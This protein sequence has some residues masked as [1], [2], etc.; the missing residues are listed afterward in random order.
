MN[1]QNQNNPLENKDVNT[2]ENTDDIEILDFGVEEEDPKASLASKKENIIIIII[3]L[4]ILLI[5]VF[6]V[7]KVYTL[8]SSGRGFVLTND[9]SDIDDKHSINGFLEIGKDEGYIIAKK[10]QFYSFIKK[11]NNVLSYKLMAETGL[12][13]VK[14]Y[15]IYIELYNSKKNV[16]YRTKFDNYDT[17]NRKTIERVNLSLNENI[18]GEATYAK[19][20]ILND[21]NF[22]V[23][24]K[25]MTCSFSDVN[26]M[27]TLNS[28]YT[29]SFS[30]N[31][32]VSYKVTRK[33]IPNPDYLTNINT[34]DPNNPLLIIG[35][36][37]ESLSKIGIDTLEYSDTDINYS[38]NLLKNSVD[39]EKYT[40]GN[41]YRQIKLESEKD[42]W[43]CE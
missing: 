32:L 4:T 38:V 26:D 11:E 43:R 12:K 29:Y 27:Y 42:N 33:L 7:P 8:L 15:N 40:L 36:E 1:E 25:D 31:G 13:D 21:K 34:T 19:L 24:D 30:T 18:Y 41:T 20:V 17:L 22:E 14:G 28:T 5:A 6:L 37:G 9:S 3:L 35:R 16:I 10:I 39:G 2:S 23:M